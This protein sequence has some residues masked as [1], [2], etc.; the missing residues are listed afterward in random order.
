M[1]ILL[2]SETFEWSQ[3]LRWYQVNNQAEMIA[4]F[5]G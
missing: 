3:K 5:L 4:L 1:R 2:E